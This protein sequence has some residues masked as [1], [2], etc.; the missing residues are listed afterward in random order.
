MKRIFII[1]CLFLFIGAGYDNEGE[2]YEEITIDYS[3]CPC[4]HETKFLKKIEQEN[5]LLFDVTETSFSEMKKL[6]SDGERANFISYSTS[7]SDTAFYYSIVGSMSH[8]GYICNFPEVATEW[9]I[10]FQGINITFSADAFELCAPKTSITT[11]SYSN[12]VLASLKK[13]KK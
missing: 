8:I 11:Q 9:K 7:I 1:A 2:E 6:S 12:L 3:K 4:E 13:E 5:V 10:P